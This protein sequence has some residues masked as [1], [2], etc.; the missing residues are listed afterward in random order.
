M[1]VAVIGA[2]I[3]GVTT[4]YELSTQGHEVHVYE[5]SGSA[6]EVCSFANAG[7]SSPGYVTP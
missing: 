5:R 2:G 7:V 1:K 6:A 3:V 4:A